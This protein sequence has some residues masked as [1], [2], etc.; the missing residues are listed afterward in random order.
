MLGSVQDSD[1]APAGG[2]VSRTTTAKNIK[3]VAD[4]SGCDPWTD[5][6]AKLKQS[7]H[8]NQQVE[9]P[10]QDSWKPKYLSSLI[11]QLVEAKYLVLEER[12]T[13]LQSLIDS[14]VR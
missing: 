7:L 2:I 1:T 13:Y 10:D 3:L 12:I 4:L 14:L 8:R 5:S 9:T 6:P 11:A